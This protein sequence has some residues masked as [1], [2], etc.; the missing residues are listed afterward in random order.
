[1]SGTEAASDFFR[2]DSPEPTQFLVHTFVFNEVRKQVERNPVLDLPLQ[3]IAEHLKPFRLGFIVEVILDDFP[4]AMGEVGQITL[5]IR[6][7]HS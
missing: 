1:M 5:Q 3:R 7:P 6:I 4:V 2:R